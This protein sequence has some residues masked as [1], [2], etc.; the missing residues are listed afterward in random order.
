M[1]HRKQSPS[2]WSAGMLGAALAAGALG[3]GLA[4]RMSP[5]AACPGSAMPAAPGFTE[6]PPPAPPAPLWGEG[7]ASAPA[8]PPGLVDPLGLPLAGRITPNLSP[9]RAIDSPSA[10][11][12][13]G[14]DPDAA[15][16]AALRAAIT[17]T[18]LF[19][20]SAPAFDPPTEPGD[21]AIP[22]PPSAG[23]P[24]PPPAGGGPAAPPSLSDAA[25]TLA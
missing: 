3:A 12:P 4:G 21:N 16:G 7:R 20:N 6:A 18:L 25:A 24:E 23:D 15:A 13:A 5:P 1:R 10:N 11:V 2:L 17:G 14:S 9:A 19:D 8:A 22:A